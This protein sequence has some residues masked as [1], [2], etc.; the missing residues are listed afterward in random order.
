MVYQRANLSQGAIARF[1]RIKEIRGYVVTG[2]IFEAAQAAKSQEVKERDLQEFKGRALVHAGYYRMIR[3]EEK[4]EVI[5]SA[6]HLREE[7][8]ASE[9]EHQAESKLNPR[10]RT[11]WISIP[12]TPMNLD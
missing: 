2:R 1:E 9:A 7:D 8:V 10:Q 5:T 11:E 12:A 3:Q 4:V 6:F